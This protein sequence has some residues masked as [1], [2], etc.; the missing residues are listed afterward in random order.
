MTPIFDTFIALWERSLTFRINFVAVAKSRFATPS[1]ATPG[2][3]NGRSIRDRK[4]SKTESSAGH[5]R[6][7]GRLIGE[8]QNIEKPYLRLTTF[9][10]KEDVRPRKVLKKA[11]HHV[12]KQYAQNGD[13]EWANEQLKSLRQDVTV[14]GIQKPF[15]LEVYEHHARISLENKDLNEFN[16]C[17]S[18][19]RSL[20]GDAA[21]GCADEV[22]AFTRAARP[23]KRRVKTLVQSDDTVD[24]FAAYALLYA[25]IQR[26]RLQ[27]KKEV[28]R[29]RRL[30]SI[31][32]QMKCANHA[33][34]VVRAVE[35]NDYRS[36]FE[37]YDSAP[38]MSGYLL[39]FMV[40]RVRVAAY[41]SM[42]AA[43]RPAIS[44]LHLQECLGFLDEEEAMRFL[45]EQDAVL[46]EDA[47]AI[48]CKASSKG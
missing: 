33:F 18:M 17:Q 13:F 22:E 12:Q 16:Q 4:G 7:N 28:I 23:N 15:V 35:G 20:T 24:E 9:P 2:S 39:D 27:L 3:T 44:V 31:R 19:I 11:L 5:A 40:D 10:R 34:D 30:V 38:E 29:I 1:G 25:L 46:V 6:R 14:Q 42:V 37:L 47:S 48:D 45:V 26:A 21:G 41:V 32:P 43:Y 36:F 8:N